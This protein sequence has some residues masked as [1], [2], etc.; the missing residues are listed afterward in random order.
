MTAMDE[1]HHKYDSDTVD[2]ATLYVLVLS[3]RVINRYTEY[4]ITCIS[5]MRGDKPIRRLKQ[6]LNHHH[7]NIVKQYQ[8]NS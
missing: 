4:L 5:Y 1:K 2:I 3:G 7:I 6:E 8:M